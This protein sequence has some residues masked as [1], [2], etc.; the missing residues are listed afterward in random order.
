MAS[1]T[2]EGSQAI[3][4]QS[5]IHSTDIRKSYP[6]DFLK[7]HINSNDILDLLLPGQQL[8]SFHLCI[9]Q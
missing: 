1:S 8:P 9:Q 2:T 6:S 5:E 7:L 3:I 4:T